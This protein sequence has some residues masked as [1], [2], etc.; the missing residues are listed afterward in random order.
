[1]THTTIRNR[2]RLETILEVTALLFIIGPAVWLIYSWSEIPERVPT[3]FN[4]GGNPDS[5]GN[6]SSLIILPLISLF[7]Y[8]L[9]TLVGQLIRKQLRQFSGGQGQPPPLRLLKTVTMLAALKAEIAWLFA[10]IAWASVTTARGEID[11]IGAFALVVF[12]LLVA[13]TVAY[14]LLKTDK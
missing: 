8:V 6:K 13:A 2:A 7:L 4:F 12:L 9:L 10:Y 11:G 3:H 5:W 1:M 14:P